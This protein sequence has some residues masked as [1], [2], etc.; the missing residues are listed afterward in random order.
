MPQLLVLHAKF[1]RSLKHFVDTD[2]FLGRGE[3]VMRIDRRSV[4]LCYLLR[5]YFAL[6]NVIIVDFGANNELD[7]VFLAILFDVLNPETEAVEALVVSHR[8]D[9]KDYGRFLIVKLIY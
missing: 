4:L 1:G 8:V 2:V 7:A 5:N 3:E 6:F 9:Q